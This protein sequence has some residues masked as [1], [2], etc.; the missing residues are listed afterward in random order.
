MS[1]FTK[2]NKDKGND[3]KNMKTTSSTSRMKKLMK[4]VKK[5]SMEFTT[6]INQLQRLKE[7]DSKVSDSEDEYEASHFQMAKIILV[8]VN[9]N[10]HGWMRN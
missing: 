10:L 7:V 5:I 1:H 3:D 6:V 8:K 2:K 4:Y 9:S